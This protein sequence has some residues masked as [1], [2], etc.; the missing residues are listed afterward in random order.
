AESVAIPLSVVVAAELF[1]NP[2]AL[3][4]GYRGIFFMLAINMVIALILLVAFV[5]PPKRDATSLPS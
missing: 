3:N 1:L 4:L 2:N 5:H